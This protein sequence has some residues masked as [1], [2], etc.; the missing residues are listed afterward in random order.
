MTATPSA[1]AE[2][3]LNVSWP[4]AALAG[5]RGPATNDTL[6]FELEVDA[7]TLPDVTVVAEPPADDWC[8]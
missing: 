4:P 2:L 8:P 3:P 6:A 1:P 7:A 5:T